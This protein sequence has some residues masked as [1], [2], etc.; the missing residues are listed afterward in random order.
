MLAL[1]INWLNLVGNGI[2]AILAI[3]LFVIVGNAINKFMRH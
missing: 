3:V 2:L 1:D